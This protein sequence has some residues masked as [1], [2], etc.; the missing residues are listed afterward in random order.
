[1]RLTH[2]AVLCAI[3]V[4]GPA[5]AQAG[6]P[7]DLLG[8]GK[9]ALTLDRQPE[10]GV[11]TF[12]CEDAGRAEALLSKLVAD[13]TWDPSLGVKPV[14]LRVGRVQATGYAL[15]EAGVALV[16]QR[17]EKVYVVAGKDR[18]SVAARATALRLDQAGVRFAAD[19][20]HP[21]GLDYFDLSALRAYYSWRLADYQYY[22]WTPEQVAGYDQ[23]ARDF[24][25]QTSFQFPFWG[26][27]GEAGDGA[28][29][30]YSGEYE[31]RRALR[32]GRDVETLSG[33]AEMPLWLWERFP[34]EVSAH[35]PYVLYGDWGGVG[36]A[37]AAHMSYWASA[38]AFA[39]AERF[40]QEVFQRYSATAGERLAA[41]A[42]LFG[43]PGV[44]AGIHHLAGDF[45]DYSPA[46]QRGFRTWLRDVQ[47][48]SLAELGER[49]YGDPEHFAAWD[50]VTI[51][52]VF[53]FFGGFG[54]ANTLN[55][56]TGWQWRLDSEAARDELWYAPA[57]QPGPEWV[58]VDLPPSQQQLFL[59]PHTRRQAAWMRQEFDPTAW[60]EKNPGKDL[61]LVA[62]TYSG[63]PVEV[64]LNNDYLGQIQSKAYFGPIG[65]KVTL[66]LRPG[67]NV[68]TV[69][70]KEGRI[71]GPVFLSTR[72]P[73]YYPNLGKGSNAR[74]VDLR[75]F[76]G[77]STYWGHKRVFSAL[78]RVNPELPFK[79]YGV[80]AKLWDYY[81]RL[82]EETG[83]GGMQFTGSGSSYQP[84]PAA[85][86]LANG[87]YQSSEEGGQTNEP[88]ILDRELAW[89]LFGAEGSHVYYYDES[90]Y[91]E[92]NDEH[93]WFDQHKRLLELVGKA[94][95]VGP[96]I[97]VLHSARNLR[98]LPENNESF[99]WGTDRGIL[100]SIQYDN[101][102]V[103]DREVLSG[104]VKAYPVLLDT[105]TTCMDEAELTALEDYVRAG[106]TFVA[107]HG[108]GRHSLTEPD[109]WGISRLTGCQ[110]IGERVNRLV[111]VL[112]DNPL[113]KRLAG[114]TFPGNGLALDYR[115][116]DHAGE[117][118]VALAPMDDQQ[119]VVPIATWEDGT[120]AVAM[121][122][123]GK[124]RVIVLGSTFWTATSD[125][126]GDGIQRTGTVNQEF[127]RDLLAGVG[128]ST[129]IE[130]D[131]PL[132]VRHMVT[133]NGLQD[134]Y[135]VY[136]SGN[137]AVTGLEFS[138]AAASKPRE[139]QDME[140]GQATPF[141]YAEGR[142][143][144][145]GL[146]FQAQ[147]VKIFGLTRG[148]WL[149]AA[150]SWYA[151]KVA[152]RKPYP[153]PGPAEAPMPPV[154]DVVLSEY[155]VT[156]TGL[157]PEGDLGWTADGYNE[158]GWQTARTGYWDDQG[159]KVEGD[160]VLYRTRFTAPA[161]WAGRSVVLCLT[162]YDTPGIFG[163]ATFY[164]NGEKIVT[165]QGH[166]WNN[167]N[168]FDALGKV[169]PGENVLAFSVTAKADQPGG[170]GGRLFFRPEVQ[171]EDVV[172][173]TQGWQLY[174]DNLQA[175]P[176]ALPG[177]VMGQSL[178]REVEIPAAWEGKPVYLH[179]ETPRQW[180]SCVVVNGR[181]LVYDQPLHPFGAR[182]D[183]RVDQYLHPGENTLELWSHT[184]AGD[185]TGQTEMAVGK[186]TMGVG[187]P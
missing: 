2:V 166:G 89:V 129:P 138:F 153:P 76:Q 96:Q 83:G 128:Q 157:P 120:I 113:L 53:S 68:L 168:V 97:A 93:H 54:E 3:L 171:L 161:A 100:Q 22:K 163:T 174:L 17:G 79:I 18:G 119:G 121:R 102:V 134:W 132:W 10:G 29:D 122:A 6:E 12:T 118:T 186:I 46:A 19:Q 69:R 32:N 130:A 27:G 28:F 149:E 176:A 180:L 183:L 182:L 45:L 86:G 85:L 164:V 66:L 51:P 34:G 133:K 1:M 70:V 115:G 108:T 127:L 23:F 41:A 91:K 75:E 159:I 62:N 95:R 154:E 73:A 81:A 77:Y 48:Y 82:L 40:T 167:M 24:G 13:I 30:T 99:A 162:S 61:Y 74:W 135:V 7:A 43:R 170:V 57:Y 36:E 136:N 145:A 151:D 143:R 116:R 15:L 101:V 63:T 94:Q 150:Q 31:I 87:F 72:Q 111:T 37:G 165:H 187:T 16:A 14:P 92:A 67:R 140:S 137:S 142:V 49:W 64:Y 55:L 9:L 59:Q 141:I 8:Y 105:N 33:P 47:G 71:L 147:E 152:F 90:L 173:L 56:L 155:K 131:E 110:V 109:T 126:A 80:D 117:G 175:T 84:W 177:K 144:V 60:L 104:V 50:E 158:A 179:V 88:S 160:T 139:V 181:P 21:A 25:L 146:S 42:A 52:S 125:L 124:G 114:M 169:H 35:D 38:P 107:L 103:T 98:L 5:L 148:D 26:V 11:A 184:T 39:Y 178:R 65:M 172:D 20:R 4:A 156:G 112:P 58:Q 185:P 106:G 123:L 44:E 78:R